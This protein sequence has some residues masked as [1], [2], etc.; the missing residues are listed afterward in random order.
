MSR[1]GSNVTLDDLINFQSELMKFSD[2]LDEIYS[3]LKNDLTELSNYWQDRK[4]FEFIENIDPQKEEIRKISESY[5][6]YAETSIQNTIDSVKDLDGS[7]M[8]V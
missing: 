5:R 7:G 4:Y 3:F 8:G 2:K 1:L 6:L